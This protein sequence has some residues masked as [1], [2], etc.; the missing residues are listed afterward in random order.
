MRVSVLRTLPST[1]IMTAFAAAFLSYADEQLYETR[2]VTQS[3]V[4]IMLVVLLVVTAGTIVRCLASAEARS[5]V[6]SLYT[7][8]TAVMLALLG[9]VCF[10]FVSAFVP[11]AKWDDGPRWVLFPAN[12]AV[13][14]LLAMLL[15]FPEHHRRRFRAYLLI[16][17]VVVTASVFTDVIRPG[18]FSNLPDRAAGFAKNP[19]IAGFLLVALCSAIVVYDRVRIVDVLIVLATSLAVL[20]TFSRGGAVLFVFFLVCYATLIA[21]HARRPGRA[22]ARMAAI[23]VVAMLVVKSATLLI[24]RAQLFS[25]STSRVGMLAGKSDVLPQRDPRRETFAV[26]LRIV[27]EAPLVGYGSGYTYTMPQGP[28]NIYLQQWI[29]N[30]LLGLVAYVWLIAAAARVFWR[31]RYHTGVVFVGLVAVEGLFS[32][33]LLEERIFL[34]LLG[35]MLTLSYFAVGGGAARPRVTSSLR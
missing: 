9:I 4:K 25:L 1:L 13:I 20:A 34:V 21:R 29:N 3:P 28:H 14:I 19:N 18:T 22:L 24:S 2:V 31:R 5:R 10:S 30:G 6:I 12:D 35:S 23:A 15:P 26:S 32:H 8:H 7:S 16:A 33:N 27:R 17:F 11:T